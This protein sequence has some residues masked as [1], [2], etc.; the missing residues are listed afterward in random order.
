LVI[1]KLD[2]IITA[3]NAEIAEKTNG[4]KKDV[5]LKPEDF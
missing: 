5:S 2:T 1:R 3:E 4:K